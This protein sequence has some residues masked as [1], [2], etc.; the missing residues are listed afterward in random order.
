MELV[1]LVGVLPAE[2]EDDTLRNGIVILGFLRHEDL[3]GDFGG[4]PADGRA[5]ANDS[6]LRGGGD[7]RSAGG[8][9][10][11]GVGGVRIVVVDVEEDE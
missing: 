6:G 3:E 7:E 1:A 11:A 9:W 5:A 2:T 10:T 8:S 4:G